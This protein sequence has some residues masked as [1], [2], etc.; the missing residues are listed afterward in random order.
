VDALGALLLTWSAVAAGDGV[1]RVIDPERTGPE[2]WLSGAIVAISV[3]LMTGFALGAVGELRRGPLLVAVLVIGLASQ[4]L[5][6]RR[7]PAA[8]PSGKDQLNPDEEP[9]WV[10]R[11][12]I[13]ACTLTGLVWAG[14][15]YKVFTRGVVDVDSHHYHLSHALRFA[16]SGEILPLHHVWSGDLAAY[17]PSNDELVRAM[18]MLLGRSD[19]PGVVWSAVAVGVGLLAAFTFGRRV[20]R[21]AT[22]TLVAAGALSIPGVALPFAGGSTNDHLALSMLMA[23]I[24]LAAG[25]S[26]RGA[27]LIVGAAAGIALGTK[28]TVLPAV[29]VFVLITLVRRAPLGH[30]IRRGSFVLGVL[31]TGTIWYAR[32]L[33]IAA[34]PVPGLDPPGPFSLNEPTAPTLASISHSVLSYAGDRDIIREHFIPGLHFAFGPLWPLAF[35]VAGI[36]VGAGLAGWRGRDLRHWLG[37][38]CAVVAVVSAVGYLLI[39]TGAGGPE[40]DPFLFRSNA[41]YLLPAL[42]L[43]G[44]SAATTLSRRRIPPLAAVIGAVAWT[45]ALASMNGAFSLGVTLL[46]AAAALCASVVRA[47]LS[48]RVLGP[49]SLVALSLG[50]LLTAQVLREP[51]LDNQYRPLKRMGPL[52][53][54]LRDV[55]A[56]TRV[57]VVGLPDQ[58]GY[59]GRDLRTTVQYVGRETADGGY[60]AWPSCEELMV[61]LSDGDYDY[62]AVNG[63]EGDLAPDERG[64]V[65]ANPAFEPVA[66]SATGG[67]VFRLTDAPEASGC[68]V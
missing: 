10:A 20:G 19:L 60:L 25:A 34:N 66:S 55:P 9:P 17:H 21:P 14:G 56:D 26:D 44:W 57:A 23:A 65:E 1:R 33:A 59:A 30:T 22:A 11:L 45:A 50:V 63:P 27:W 40:G 32:N 28:L 37:V 12:A 47:E 68:P 54:A 24:A 41:R 8:P 58:Y 35:V 52:F 29:A 6:R 36:G 15:A 64:W 18:G 38:T 62:L 53:L 13:G 49:V 7:A 2:A 48:W 4:W 46:A 31:A 43:G 67:A 39:P 42:V 3:L 5:G 51:Y 61:A 16:Q